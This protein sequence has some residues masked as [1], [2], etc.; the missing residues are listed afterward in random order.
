MHRRRL[1]AV[2]R[3]HVCSGVCCTGRNG[4]P[5]TRVSRPARPA[6]TTINGVWALPSWRHGCRG[7]RSATRRRA[8]RYQRPAPSAPPTSIGDAGM[9]P[10]GGS[11]LPT[12]EY[13]PPHQW[14]AQP[15]PSS[16]SGTDSRRVRRADG[17]LVHADASA[18]CTTPHCDGK[19]IAR[20]SIRRTSSSGDSSAARAA[21][22]TARRRAPANGRTLRMIDGATGAEIRTPRAPRWWGSSA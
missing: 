15:R 1:A 12:R 11:C 9:T 10:D 2:T 4:V 18:A 5:S 6:R 22:A 7:S 16:G 17:P 14:H 13:A 21:G 20:G 19:L 8:S 3:L